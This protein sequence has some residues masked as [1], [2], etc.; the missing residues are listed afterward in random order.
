MRRIERQER[1]E[2]R[3]AT[4]WKQN[5]LDLPF[6]C[7]EALKGKRMARKKGKKVTEKENKEEKD[8]WRENSHGWSLNILFSFAVC[9]SNKKERLNKEENKAKLSDKERK[10]STEYRPLNILFYCT[11]S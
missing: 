7:I 6:Y 3:K 1:E 4:E 10:R 2:G 5:D 9:Y 11:A 8:A